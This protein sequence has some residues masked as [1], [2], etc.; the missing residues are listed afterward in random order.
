MVTIAHRRSSVTRF[1]FPI[2]YQIS[3][4]DHPGHE[5]AIGN[6]KKLALFSSLYENARK[7]QLSFSKSMTG[8][9]L[10]VVSG[11]VC[12]EQSAR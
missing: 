3:W 12:P 6:K 9:R 5:N 8:S 4:R 10:P 7:A 11:H 2:L 1:L